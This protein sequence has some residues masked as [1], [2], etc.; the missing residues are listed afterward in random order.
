MAGIKAGHRPGSPGCSS[1]GILVGQLELRQHKLGFPGVFHAGGTLEEQLEL[2]QA[3]GS[4]MFCSG[5][6]L[7]SCLELM[8]YGPGMFQCASCLCH[9]AEMVRAVVN[10]DQ[11]RPDTNC[12]SATFVGQLGL[13]WAKDLGLIELV[14]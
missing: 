12:A 14:G 11:E 2:R 10:T 8:C 13:V 3:E 7:A 1:P 6:A 4:S 5:D 9:L